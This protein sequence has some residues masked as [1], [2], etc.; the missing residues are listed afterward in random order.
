MD[1]W[2]HVLQENSNK[3][4]ACFPLPE[5]SVFHQLCSFKDTAVFKKLI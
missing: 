5:N 1:F 3:Y 2:T 4:V